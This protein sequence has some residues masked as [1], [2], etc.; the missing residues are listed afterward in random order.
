MGNLKVKMDNFIALLLDVLIH[1][2]LLKVENYI[3]WN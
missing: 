2:I 3:S 1:G